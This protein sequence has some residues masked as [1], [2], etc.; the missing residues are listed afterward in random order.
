[1]LALLLLKL[2][3]AVMGLK[4]MEMHNGNVGL[5]VLLVERND[6]N[7]NQWKICFKKENKSIK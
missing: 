2:D 7:V 5:S 3:P 6:F 1:M 4:T